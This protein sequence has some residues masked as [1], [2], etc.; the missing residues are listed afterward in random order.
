MPLALSFALSTWRTAQSG[1]TNAKIAAWGGV[2]FA[3]VILLGLF[4]T[5][6]KGGFLAILLAL[7]VFAIALWRVQKAAIRQALRAHRLLAI[8][9]LLVLVVGGGALATKTVG[10]RLRHIGAIDDNSTMFRVYTWRSTIEMAEARPLFGWGPGSYQHAHG[11]FA[12]VGVTASAH[13]VW[14]QIAA[15]TVFPRCCSY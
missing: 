11:A 13:Q 9:C 2:L 10:P 12:Q 7:L 3:L 6:S 5:S 8:A 1:Q 15:S 4:V 14:L